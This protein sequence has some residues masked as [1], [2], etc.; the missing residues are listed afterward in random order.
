[1]TGDP[2]VLLTAL[3]AGAAAA[4][5]LRGTSTAPAAGPVLV[6]VAVVVGGA[7]VLLHPDPGHL[8]LL[9]VGA[10]V[11]AMAAALVR[12]RRRRLEARRRQASLLEACGVLSSELTAGQPPATALGR[13]V[14]VWPDLAPVLRSHDLGADVPEAWRSLARHPGAHDALVLAAAWQVSHRSGRG[15]GE[16]L[17]RVAR[18]LRG[19]AA[20]RRVVESELASARATARLLA[21]LPV[22]ALVVGGGTVPGSSPWGFLLGTPVGLACLG[23]GLSLGFLGLWWIEAIAD[24]VERRC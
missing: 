15:L 22:L 17:A 18:G 9:L 12:R 16:A 13:A 2:A 4:C 8:V 24:D 3:M 23:A 7:A 21:A 5:A 11:L 20:T 6:V 19:A 14:R 10:G 1:M